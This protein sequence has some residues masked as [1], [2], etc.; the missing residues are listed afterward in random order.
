MHSLLNHPLVVDFPE[1]KEAIQALKLSNAH[2]KHLLD[3]YQT[4]DEGIVRIETELEAA[5]DARTEQLKRR[6]LQLKDELMALV[7]SVREV[8]RAVMG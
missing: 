2:F 7:L 5:S 8:H 1:H 4:V 3:Q 6:R